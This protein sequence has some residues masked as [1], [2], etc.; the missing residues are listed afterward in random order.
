VG[1]SRNFVQGDYRELFRLQVERSD[2]AVEVAVP[3]KQF[4]D[5]RLACEGTERERARKRET[6]IERARQRARERKSARER[7]REKRGGGGG[8]QERAKERARERARERTTLS[9]RIA[10]KT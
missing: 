5:C 10:R 2:E 7:E 6:E 3:R 4:A 9:E 8:G 1:V